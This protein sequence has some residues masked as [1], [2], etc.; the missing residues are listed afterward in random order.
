VRRYVRHCS[1]K[2]LAYCELGTKRG[3]PL[4]DGKQQPSMQRSPWGCF[5]SRT[6]CVGQAQ[7]GRDTCDA[8]S[9]APPYEQ[10][11]SQ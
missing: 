1:P 7:S 2:A 4:M 11:D 10:F 5:S 8:V 6:L 3:M 9:T